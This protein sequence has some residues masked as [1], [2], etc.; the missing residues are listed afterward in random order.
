MKIQYFI[1]VSFCLFLLWAVGACEK[2]GVDEQDIEV[3]EEY[4]L[5]A[6]ISTIFLNPSKA[7]DTLAD[8]LSGNYASCFNRGDKLY[9][10]VRTTDN[11]YGGGLGPV[12]AGYS[13]GSCHRNAGRTRPEDL[14]CTV[15]IPLRHVG[16]GQI[17]ALDRT[18]IETL[19][20]KSNYPEYGISGRCNYINERGI[21]SLGVSGNKAQH[22]DLTVE[23]G[24]RVI[25]E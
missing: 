20:A 24:F 25:W 7:Y 1:N 10:D 19:V 17:M 18:E 14:F 3:P 4:A 11:S 9:D 8:W 21:L 16:M 23:L 12:Y 5:S 13:C 6:G 15:R 2:E 22:A